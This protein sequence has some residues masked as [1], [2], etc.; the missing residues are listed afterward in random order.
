MAQEIDQPGSRF[1]AIQTDGTDIVLSSVPQ[2][3][4][5]YRHVAELRTFRMNRGRAA[6]LDAYDLASYPGFTTALGFEQIGRATVRLQLQHIDVDQASMLRRL[7]SQTA[8][9]N[10]IW[11]AAPKTTEGL[12]LAPATVAT[13]LRLGAVNGPSVATSVRA[14]ALSATFLFVDKASFEL[15]IDPDEFDVI[16]PV[17]YRPRG[18]EAVPLLQVVDHLVN[19]AGFCLRLSESSG[20]IPMAAELISEL[21]SGDSSSFP[22]DQLLD[23]A[24]ATTCDQACYKCLLR[25]RNQ[26]YHGLLDWQLALTFLQTLLSADFQCGLDGEFGPFLGLERW[27]MWA[28]RYAK[29]MARLYSGEASK[30]GELWSF[31]VPGRLD[32]SVVIVHPLWDRQSPGPVL[33]EAPEELTDR[34]DAAPHMADTFN[35]ARRPGWV[36]ERLARGDTA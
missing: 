15:D 8:G 29:Q 25:Y 31:T 21:L 23:E 18:G 35:L 3:N 30:A 27:P 16:E 5:T 1:R 32:R 12:Y 34:F 6:Q 13:G 33:R 7:Q 9:E 14:A 28:E 20:S 10:G 36:I 11:L 2:T 22:L 4:M 19:G 24:H 26:P 17:W